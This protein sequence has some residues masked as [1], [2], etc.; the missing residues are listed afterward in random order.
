MET[1]Q[2]Y[3]EVKFALPLGNIPETIRLEAERKAKE[4]YVMTLLRHADISAGLA[5][6]LLGCDRWQLSDL[7]DLYGIS[8]FPTLTR[9]ELEEEVASAKRSL[10]KYRNQ[11]K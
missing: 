7:M 4:A 10:E 1:Q 9:E 2:L 5:A 8:P 3:T 11:Q 6:E